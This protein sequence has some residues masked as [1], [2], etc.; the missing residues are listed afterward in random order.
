VLSRDQLLDTE[1]GPFDRTV[2][3][4]VSRLRRKLNDDPRQPR[5]IKTVRGGG[6]IFTAPVEPGATSSPPVDPAQ[7][8]DYAEP[9]AYCTSAPGAGQ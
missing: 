7:R 3:V 4:Q 8:D 5:L 6:Y 1:A 9:S 2:D